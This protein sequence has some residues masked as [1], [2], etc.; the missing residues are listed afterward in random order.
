M[1]P[2]GSHTAAQQDSH[3]GSSAAPA[4]VDQLQ[5]RR[6][7]LSRESA[8]SFDWADTLTTD[9]V[10]LHFLGQLKLHSGPRKDATGREAIYRRAFLPP[11]ARRMLHAQNSVGTPAQGDQL[12][13]E[14]A[15]ICAVENH[16]RE[17]DHVKSAALEATV[18]YD[19]H[20]V[21]QLA[22]A[23]RTP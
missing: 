20:K 19:A 8:Q 14:T 12:N 4:P 6:A 15:Y 22:P 11:A 1:P 3:W 17:F 13:A 23:R 21:F 10:D 16:R 5:L 2:V 9:P 7:N 18:G